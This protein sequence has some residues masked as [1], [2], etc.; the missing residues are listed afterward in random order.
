VWGVE[1]TMFTWH[2]ALYFV[3]AVRV[4]GWVGCGAVMG[5]GGPAGE[6]WTWQGAVQL[7]CW[8]HALPAGVYPQPL[9]D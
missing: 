4:G 9:L 2:N 3:Y 6:A 1:R 5:W 7:D 8:P